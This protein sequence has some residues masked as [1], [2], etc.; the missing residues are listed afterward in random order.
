LK[1]RTL[2]TWILIGLIEI[3]IGLILMTI[4]PIFLNS[5]RPLIGFLIWLFVL[6]LLVSSLIWVV[7]RVRD[8]YQSR[9]LFIRHFPQYRQ[10]GVIDFLDIPF[11][12]VKQNLLMLEAVYNDPDWEN[13]GMSLLDLLKGDKNHEIC[14]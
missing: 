6:I 1:N 10:L 13:L 7:W 3:V 14:D 12:R 11:H 9:K 8:A 5:D 4:A 2:Q